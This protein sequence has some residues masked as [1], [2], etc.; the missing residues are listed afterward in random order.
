MEDQL[1]TIR[2]VAY[3][4]NKPLSWLYQRTRPSAGVNDFIPFIRLG[5][6]I[7]FR[8]EDV[9]RYLNEKVAQKEHEDG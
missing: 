5:A 7:R 8:P 6:H 3:R 4:L 9:E 1:I 2:Q